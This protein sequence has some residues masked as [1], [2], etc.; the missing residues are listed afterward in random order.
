[1]IVIHRRVSLKESFKDSF[2]IA[3]SLLHNRVFGLVLAQ[4]LISEKIVPSY[5]GG[6]LIVYSLGVTLAPVFLSKITGA[7][8]KGNE[9]GYDT[10]TQIP[11]SKV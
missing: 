10:D 7:S 5:L 8:I 4:I 9:V 6:A 11:Q 2:P 3:A 1:M